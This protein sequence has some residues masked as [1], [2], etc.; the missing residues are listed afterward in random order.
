MKRSHSSSP[1]EKIY[2]NMCV[3]VYVRREGV[4]F[5]ELVI[6]ESSPVSVS[7]FIFNTF[8]YNECKPTLL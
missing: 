8:K 2:K 7:P 1:P 3:Y 5:G 4:N 6:R